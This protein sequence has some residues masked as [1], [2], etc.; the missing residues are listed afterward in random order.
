MTDGW[1]ILY[2]RSK[3]QVP[4]ASWTKEEVQYHLFHRVGLPIQYIL[5]LTTEKLL[6]IFAWLKLLGME[7][8]TLYKRLYDDDRGGVMERYYGSGLPVLI[9]ERNDKSSSSLFSEQ[10]L[11][12]YF[13]RLLGNERLA[14]PFLPPKLAELE[15]DIRSSQGHLGVGRLAYGPPAKDHTIVVSPEPNYHHHLEYEA[16]IAKNEKQQEVIDEL[17]EEIFELEYQLSAL[18]EKTYCDHP[19]DEETGVSPQSPRKKRPKKDYKD[20]GGASLAIDSPRPAKAKPNHVNPSSTKNRKRSQCK[21]KR[22]FDYASSDDTAR[23]PT[24]KMRESKN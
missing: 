13:I 9:R 5:T 4:L 19:G 22:P 10:D 1:R 14:A 24:K 17:M 15:A 21:E 20:Q 16:S 23:A 8:N 11:Q 3:Q 12:Y 6:D 18:Q 2:S 7:E